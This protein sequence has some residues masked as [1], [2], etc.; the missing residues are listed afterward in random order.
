METDEALLA[1]DLIA[2][3]VSI[4]PESGKIDWPIGKRSCPQ[5]MLIKKKRQILNQKHNWW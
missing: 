1:E 4:D 2:N 5:M 3:G